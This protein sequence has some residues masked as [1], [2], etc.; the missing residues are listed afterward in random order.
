[1]TK[2]YRSKANCL[3]YSLTEITSLPED[4][5]SEHT[6]ND[7]TNGRMT[8][9]DV[10]EKQTGA[11]SCGYT[12]IA[13][14][15]LTSSADATSNGSCDKL[16][17]QSAPGQEELKGMWQSRWKQSICRKIPGKWMGRFGGCAI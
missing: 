12:A 5:S 7:V 10:L 4:T 14:A 8:S 3:F 2:I 16:T 13:N 1:M 6:N 9:D 11:S 15:S 17:D